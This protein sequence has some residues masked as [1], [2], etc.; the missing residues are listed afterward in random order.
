MQLDKAFTAILTGFTAVVAS[1]RIKF[2]KAITLGITIADI[3]E[4]NLEKVMHFP[5]GSHDGGHDT[6]ATPCPCYLGRH[7]LAAVAYLVN[8]TCHPAFSQRF[9]LACLSSAV[10][11]TF[12]GQ[13]CS[14]RV[15]Q[16][17]P[18]E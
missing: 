2:A 12:D 8:C 9:C 11:S 15:P 18:I 10:L 4:D 14:S 13:T 6:D 17:A 5:H 3:I 16:V 1:V 7:L